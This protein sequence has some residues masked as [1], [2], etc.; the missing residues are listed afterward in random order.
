MQTPLNQKGRWHKSLPLSNPKQLFMSQPI[1]QNECKNC[2]HPLTGRTD[3]QFCNDYCRNNYHNA[4][5]QQDNN[6]TRNIT[7]VIR[8]NRSKLKGLVNKQITTLNKA[9]LDIADFNWNYHTHCQTNSKG[10]VTTYCF[11]FGFQ[12]LP[13][14]KIKII[15]HTKQ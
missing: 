6:L 2:Q 5:N 12:I 4:R 1:I 7:A 13:N 3:K 14:N 15:H 10:L 8:R 11:D 9:D